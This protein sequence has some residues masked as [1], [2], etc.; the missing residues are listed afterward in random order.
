MHLKSNNSLHALFATAYLIFTLAVPQVVYATT[1][2]VNTTDDEL[3]A[4]GDCSLREAIRAAN[5]DSM[6]DACPGGSGSDEI[7]FDANVV[8]GTFAL[9]ISGTG[10]DDAVTGDLDITDE[11]II[12]G[13]GAGNTIIDALGIDRVFQV[14]GATAFNLDQLT[15]QGG[16]A[17]AGAGILN[18]SGTLTISSSTVR[19]NVANRG[20]GIVN[21]GMMI[22]NNSIIIDNT[23]NSGGGGGIDNDGAMTIT[24]ST[25]VGNSS[26]LEGGGIFAF[27]TLTIDNTTFTNNTSV[28]SV[29]GGIAT[30]GGGAF[31]VNNSTFSGNVAGIRGGGIA[32]LSGTFDLQS[33]T[34]VGN[35]APDG[36]DCFGTIT[37]LGNNII[38]DIA[39]CDIVLLATDDTDSDGDGVFDSDDN[40]PSLENVD[41]L[42]TD[43]DGQGDVCDSDDDNDGLIDDAEINIYG[44]DPLNS[45]TD[46]DGLSDGTEINVH[47]TNPLKRDTD[48]DGLNDGEEIANGLDPL[49]ATDCPFEL[50]PPHSNVL[51]LILEIKSRE[52]E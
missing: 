1:I 5:T 18:N 44:T 39:G 29:G 36:S 22:I 27:G 15:V 30:G 19:D 34:I 31:T 28:A 43:N 42:D 12:T 32:H 24:N 47:G 51:K 9:S 45:D 17:S 8:P 10:E 52:E 2:T 16:A 6:I 37:S 41:Q 21:D 23:A 40:C 7:V 33:T 48:E 20:G 38:E 14:I 49:D 26:Q 46:G 4:D 50:C 25:I 13:S 35:S 11:L 3:N